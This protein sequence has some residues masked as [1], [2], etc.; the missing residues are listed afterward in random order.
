MKKAIQKNK[1]PIY[2]RYEFSDETGCPEGGDIFQFSST[3][4]LQ[5]FMSEV[6]DVAESDGVI[7]SFMVGQGDHFFKFLKNS[8]LTQKEIEAEMVDPCLIP[9]L[10][11]E[12]DSHPKTTKAE[13]DS[14]PK[15][16]QGEKPSKSKKAKKKART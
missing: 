15:K 8:G 7:V 2:F 13:K 12:K 9:F 1:S 14:H 11:D 4:E 10:L 5:K 6:I 16:P 3:T